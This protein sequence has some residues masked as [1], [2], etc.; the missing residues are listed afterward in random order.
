MFRF[1]SFVAAVLAGTGPAAAQ[2]FSQ[3]MA[4]CAGLYEAA[5]TMVASE[6]NRAKLAWAA[7]AFSEA[8]RVQAGAEGQDDPGAWVNR[9]QD[10]MRADWLARGTPAVLSQDFRDWTSYCR[11]FAKDRG[12]E[13]VVD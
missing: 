9:H 8:A 1:L 10:A 6:D 13:L 12:I 7:A 4:Q 2:P 3:S 5:G 11:K